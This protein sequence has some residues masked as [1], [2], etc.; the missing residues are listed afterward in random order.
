MQDMYAGD[1]GDFG[2]F[3]LLKAIEGQKLKD[4]N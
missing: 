4:G 2:K 1:I 3:G